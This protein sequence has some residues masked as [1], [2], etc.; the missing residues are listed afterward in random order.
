[1]ERELGICT[2]WLP[3][4]Q[5]RLVFMFLVIDKFIVNLKITALRGQ[6]LNFRLKKRTYLIMSVYFVS[7]SLL[8]SCEKWAARENLYY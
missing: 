5:S 2:K 1:M 8:D 7:T 3:Q 4:W 6:K